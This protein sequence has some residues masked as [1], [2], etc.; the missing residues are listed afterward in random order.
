MWYLAPLQQIVMWLA[1]VV[2]FVLISFWVAMDKQLK[3]YE[4]V[5]WWCRVL[6]RVT[7]TR[8]EA[9]GLENVPT[10]P[11][12]IISNHSSHLDGPGLIAT[13]PDPIYFVIKKGL[14]Q[15]PVWGWTATRIGF[16]AIDRSRSKA[17][18][19]KL[20]GALSKIREGKHILV[21]AEGTR[22]TDHRLQPFK[23]G[24]FHLAIEAGV[25]ILPVAI[26]GSRRLMPKGALSS[27]PGTVRFVVGAPI[28][29]EG[30]TKE[31]LPK[32]MEQTR[33]VVLSGRRLDPDFIDDDDSRPHKD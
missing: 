20:R 14:A 5:R 13:L 21:F 31:D 24:G 9:Q 8:Y 30:L 17:A 26:N 3:A 22:S 15:I 25:P 27:I 18:Q 10:G 12:L 2:A 11:Y 23:K 16:I 6:H 19:E 28:E 4:V 7:F 1:T 32:L 33:E 29:T